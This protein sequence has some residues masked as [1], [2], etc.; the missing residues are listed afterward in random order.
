M[1]LLGANIGECEAINH[2]HLVPSL[3][4]Q[5]LLLY[6]PFCGSKKGKVHPVT[7]HEAPDGKQRYTFILS[8]TLVLER[9]GWSKP[10]TSCF[11]PV[12]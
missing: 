5:T 1:F 7:V 11:T 10:S 2:L 6:M 8:L 3:I 12:K 9:G 4:I